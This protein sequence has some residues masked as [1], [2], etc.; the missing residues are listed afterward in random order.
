ML[1]VQFLHIFQNVVTILLVVDEQTFAGLHAIHVITAIGQIVDGGDVINLVGVNLLAIEGG[2]DEFAL[3][4]VGGTQFLA[5]G[6]TVTSTHALHAL[7]E[8]IARDGWGD[9][10][11]IK[12]KNIYYDGT[13]MM[14][15]PGPRLKDAVIELYNFVYGDE[16]EEVPAA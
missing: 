7:D 1:V 6:I 11:A 12:D 4:V 14:T 10:T 16:A 3:V 2:L 15:R 8:I 9:I 13:S 5:H